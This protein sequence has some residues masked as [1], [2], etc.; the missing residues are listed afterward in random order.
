MNGTFIIL[1]WSIQKTCVIWRSGG[2]WF[3]PD[4]HI[5]Y[6]IPIF[7][8]ER[9]CVFSYSQVQSNSFPC[10]QVIRPFILL[11]QVVMCMY[12]MLYRVQS[13]LF[14][15]NHFVYEIIFENSLYTHVYEEQDVKI[16]RVAWCAEW[17]LMRGEGNRGRKLLFWNLPFWFLYFSSL[18]KSSEIPHMVKFTKTFFLNKMFS[19]LMKF[20]FGALLSVC[21]EFWNVLCI[22][23][24]FWSNNLIWIYQA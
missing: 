11:L 3:P 1:K 18:M 24:W 9:L 17:G 10:R 8:V 20:R 12:N 14:L 21:W 23:L 6:Y 13:H 2:F 5:I 7:P 19:F 15:Y 16:H 4:L 22:I